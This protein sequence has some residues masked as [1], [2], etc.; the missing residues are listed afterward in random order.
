[1]SR[2]QQALLAHTWEL[3]K[4]RLQSK[5]LVPELHYSSNYSLYQHPGRSLNFVFLCQIL[6]FGIALLLT[7][8]YKDNPSKN[9]RLPKINLYSLE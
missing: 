4:P 7:M 5:A 3:S 8:D 6:C 1:M 9:L 2:L